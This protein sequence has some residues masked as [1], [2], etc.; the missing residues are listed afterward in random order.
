MYLSASTKKAWRS[1]MDKVT[2]NTVTGTILVFLGVP[3]AVHCIVQTMLLDSKKFEH[4][5]PKSLL[6]METVDAK[7]TLFCIFWIAFLFTFTGFTL[8]KHKDKF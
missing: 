4:I 1:K 8:V 5:Y 2:R 3:L 7:M 6:L